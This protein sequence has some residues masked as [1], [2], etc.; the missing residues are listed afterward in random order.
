MEQMEFPSDKYHP[1][2]PKGARQAAPLLGV[3]L[4]FV[5][6]GMTGERGTFGAPR[7]EQVGGDEG[8][9]DG[10][11]GDDEDVEDF[12]VAEDAGGGVGP[13]GGVG[14]GAD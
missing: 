11:A 6:G 1:R 3:L 14:D 13:A 5:Q 8:E 12:V 7:L 4:D 2:R 9:V 10:G